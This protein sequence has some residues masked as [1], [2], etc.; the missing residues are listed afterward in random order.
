[1]SPL[2]KKKLNIIR[3]KLDNLDNS[4][5]NVIKKRTDLV[6]EVLKLKEHKIQ[7]VDQNRIKRILKNIRNKSIKKKIDPKIT[8]RIWYNM[9]YAY[10]DFEKRNFKKK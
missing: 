8:K 10:I 9:I 5:I 7:I 2:K 1:M 6:K 4:L 3:K